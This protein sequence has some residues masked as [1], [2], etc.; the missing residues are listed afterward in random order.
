[1]TRLFARLAAF[2]LI[3]APAQAQSV[4][5]FYRGKTI[6]IV[7]GADVGGGYDLTARTVA[8]YL[9]RHIPGAP[10][11]VVQN[12]PGAS[13]VVAVNYVYEIAPKDGTV[14]GAAQRPIPFQ[15]LFDNAGVRFDVRKMQW[16]GS[17]ANELGVVVVWHGAP[18]QSVDDLFRMETVVGGDGPALDTEIFPRALNRVLGTRFRIVGGYPGQAQIVL[19]MER[20]EVQGTGN[21]SFSDIEKGHPDWIRDKTIRMLLQLGLTKSGNPDLAGVPLVMDI[22]KTDGERQ[23]LSALMGMKALG[24]PFFV[25]PE[26]LPDRTKA[27]QDAFMATMRDPQFLD[28]AKRVLGPLDPVAGPD[29]QKI[30]ASINAL[31]PEVIGDARAAVKVSAGN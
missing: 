9:G 29:M 1:M 15:I 16:L 25:A 4:A 24:R 17:T 28:E 8:H 11:I 23:V 6:T 31:P 20:G 21:W 12:K 5:D 18:Q 2:I 26:V 7:V 13:S 10:S 22:A 27:L 30:I 3:A 19:A 14:I